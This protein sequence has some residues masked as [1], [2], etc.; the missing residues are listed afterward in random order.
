MWHLTR[1]FNVS[2]CYPALALSTVNCLPARG[3]TYS[4]C[5]GNAE[6]EHVN[7]YVHTCVCT[8]ISIQ[9]NKIPACSYVTWVHH[10]AQHRFFC[11]S[12]TLCDILYVKT[13]Q[14]SNLWPND[15]INSQTKLWRTRVSES[16]T[17]LL[18]SST[19]EATQETT[20]TVVVPLQLWQRPLTTARNLWNSCQISPNSIAL[21]QIIWLRPD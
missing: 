21:Q 10:M 13:I 9:F 19:R 12:W 1:K 15:T 17:C 7:I 18:K 16:D 20:A 4:S 2:S 3:V 5:D 11:V 6:K 14:T 8:C